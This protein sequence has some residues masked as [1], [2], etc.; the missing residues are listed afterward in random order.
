M[1]LQYFYFMSAIFT[2]AQK[3]TKISATFVQKFV[4]QMFQK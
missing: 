3:V 1:Y 4:A 2:M